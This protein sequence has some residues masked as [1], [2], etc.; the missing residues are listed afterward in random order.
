MSR[1]GGGQCCRP[2]GR[3]LARDFWTD[4]DAVRLQVCTEVQLHCQGLELSSCQQGGVKH[5]L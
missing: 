1:Q 4:D 2:M 5:W 3:C